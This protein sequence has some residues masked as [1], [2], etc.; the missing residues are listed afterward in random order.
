MFS[1]WFY[2]SLSEDQRRS[3]FSAEKDE[4][5]DEDEEDEEDEED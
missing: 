5:D 1:W 4:K 3:H 2:W